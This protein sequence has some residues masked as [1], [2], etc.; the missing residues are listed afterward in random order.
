MQVIIETI[1]LLMIVTVLLCIPGW[2]SPILKKILD[3][4]YFEIITHPRLDKVIFIIG[5]AY[6]MVGGSV[7][8]A[9]IYRLLIQDNFSPN[10]A[11]YGIMMIIVGAIMRIKGNKNV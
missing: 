2:T 4:T 7:F 1:V 9:V 5:D 3:L 6:Y 8:G 10:A 11:L